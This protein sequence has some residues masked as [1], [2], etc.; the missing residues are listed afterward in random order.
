M[1]KLYQYGDRLLKHVMDRLQGADNLE[2]G[3]RAFEERY[4]SIVSHT[5]RL[6]R[7][8]SAS[9]VVIVGGRGVAVLFVRRLHQDALV[10]SRKAT[11]SRDDL[12]QQRNMCS[13]APVTVSVRNSQF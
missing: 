1:R 7:H 6:A 5:P 13:R 10:T 11:G 8:L 3:F 4:D 9:D 2:R 12:Q